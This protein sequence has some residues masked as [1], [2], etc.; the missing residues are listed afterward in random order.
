VETVERFVVIVMVIVMVVVML[1]VKSM[2]V[3]EMLDLMSMVFTMDTR[4]CGVVSAT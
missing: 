3:E 4:L 1:A 2:M